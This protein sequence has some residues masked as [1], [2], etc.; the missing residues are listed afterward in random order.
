MEMKSLRKHFH[1]GG[2]IESNSICS[3]DIFTRWTLIYRCFL[4]DENTL[5]AAHLHCLLLLKKL[6]HDPWDSN[7]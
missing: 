2:V 1:A 5:P 6:K 7:L 4:V 3:I